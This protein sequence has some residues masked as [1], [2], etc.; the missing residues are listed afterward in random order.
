MSEAS[1]EAT[2]TET[3]EVET[4]SADTEQQPDPAAEV[5]KWKALAQKHE[6][7]AKANAEKA[8]GYDT[9]KAS[10]MTEQEKAVEAAREEARITAASEYGA[11]LAKS[12]IRATAATA[13]AD[14]DGVFDYLDLS[15]FVGEDGEPNPKAIKAF[16]D[17]LPKKSTT[18]S[19]DG[20]SRGTAKA[21][22]DMNQIIRRAA[23]HAG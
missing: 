18:P 22:G 15:R 4:A 8:K 2:T 3:T 5:E 23:G 14:L 9:L 11:R 10:Q 1:T 20:G 16:V 13:S 12:E 7:R 6:Q 19:F 17:G 21:T